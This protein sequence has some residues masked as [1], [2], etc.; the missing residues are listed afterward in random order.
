MTQF[1]FT[2]FSSSQYRRIPVSKRHLQPRSHPDL[3]PSLWT[4]LWVR[5]RGHR[6]IYGYEGRLTQILAV[7]SVY[8]SSVDDTSA[9]SDCRGY[10]L[11]QEFADLKV[12]FLSLSS[13]GNFTG[14]NCP[15][16]FISDDDFPK[17]RGLSTIMKS[18]IISSGNSLPI[19]LFQYL[20]RSRKLF[21]DHSNR[22]S[23]F[24]LL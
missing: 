16:G 22:P 3:V 23:T 6:K 14:T 15:N 13:S 19:A 4:K 7:A 5:G 20:N 9:L 8:A 18:S 21:L 2:P 17:K 11:G 1:L 24:P 12:H 10:G